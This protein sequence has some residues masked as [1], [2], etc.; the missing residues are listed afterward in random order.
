M[1]PENIPFGKRIR[2][3]EGITMYHRF[4]NSPDVRTLPAGKPSPKIKSYIL[5]DGGYYAVEG[6][7]EGDFYIKDSDKLEIVPDDAPDESGILSSAFYSVSDW[8]SNT[9]RD[10]GG[11]F[12]YLRKGFK[13][14]VDDVAEFVP[15]S[16]GDLKK[17]VLWIA[18]PIGGILLLLIINNLSE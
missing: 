14:S 11:Q 17:I 16:V 12:Y 8:F 2:A 4:P 18:I 13:K 6:N 3:D 1:K 5:P 7:K 9:D 10:I 15:D